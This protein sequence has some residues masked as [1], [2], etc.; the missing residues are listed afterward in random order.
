MAFITNVDS[1]PKETVN[2]EN[3]VKLCASQALEEYQFT[4]AIK[5]SSVFYFQI[6]VSRA[7]KLKEGDWHC[8]RPDVDNC[9][10]SVLDGCNKVAWADDCLI[11]RIEAEKRWT[12]GVARAEVTIEEIQ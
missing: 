8:Q 7:K 4:G 9:K 10:K 5:V 2:Y 6:P 1:T 3:L 11:C 12:T